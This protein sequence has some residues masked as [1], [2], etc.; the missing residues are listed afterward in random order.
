[1]GLDWRGTI[2]L[3]WFRWE[4]Y[5]KWL[6]RIIY[7]MKWSRRVLCDRLLAR[8]FWPG[9]TF[10]FKLTFSL[11]LAVW[12]NKNSRQLGCVC[13]DSP[14]RPWGVEGGSNKLRA[15]TV[16]FLSRWI[17]LHIYDR[18]T[19]V[20]PRVIQAGLST[21]FLG[22]IKNCS[23]SLPMATFD[24]IAVPCGVATFAIGISIMS[25][26]HPAK[27]RVQTQSEWNQKC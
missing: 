9:E 6:S 1:M 15:K 11:L 3:S 22:Q 17:L 10:I 18:I 13:F 8:G 12:L 7:N 2:R 24:C 23:V 25:T 5:S 14:L 19:L 21:R 20:V 4:G 26:R 16:L 27:V